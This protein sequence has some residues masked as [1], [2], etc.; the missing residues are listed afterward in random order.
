MDCQFVWKWFLT[1]KVNKWISKYG[2]EK[3]RE[4]KPHSCLEELQTEWI[5][6]IQKKSLQTKETSWSECRKAKADWIS[7]QNRHSRISTG[8]LARNKRFSKGNQK[9]EESSKPLIECKFYRGFRKCIK[10]P[11]K[12]FF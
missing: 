12:D 3:R 1:A 6:Q 2:S 7:A 10:D 9:I 5:E 8:E 11:D 4:E